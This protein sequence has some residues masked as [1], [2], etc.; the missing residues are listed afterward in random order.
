MNRCNNKKCTDFRRGYSRV[1]DRFCGTCGKEL[2]DGTPENE[3]FKCECGRKVLS[4]DN[5]CPQCGINICMCKCGKNI[6]NDK[7]VAIIN[8]NTKA[9]EHLCLEC[10]K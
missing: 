10:I 9:E 7:K 5:F 6:I 3:L 2:K 8:E 4:R 1:K